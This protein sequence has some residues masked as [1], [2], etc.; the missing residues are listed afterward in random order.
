MAE[1]LDGAD[2][3]TRRSFI[4][5]MGTVYVYPVGRGH[6]KLPVTGR[7]KWRANTPVVD[8]AALPAGV[9]EAEVA[10]FLAAVENHRAGDTNDPRQ[11]PLVAAGR[12]ASA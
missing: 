4:R 5:E 6:G 9:L 8:Y 11:I 7:I 2:M 10:E 3:E 1:K 12:N